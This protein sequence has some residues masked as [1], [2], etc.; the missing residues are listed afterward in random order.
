[1]KMPETSFFE[2]QRQFSAEIDCLNHIKKMRWPNGF[3]CP[4]CSCEH[5]YE[6]T[7]RN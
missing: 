5:A 7:T 4:R 1:M 6:L 2:W 3:V